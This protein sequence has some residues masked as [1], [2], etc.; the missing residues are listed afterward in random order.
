M[1]NNLDS[2][3]SVIVYLKFS[4][5][6]KYLEDFAKGNWYFNDAEFF[7]KL[8]ET[9]KIRGQGDRNELQYVISSGKL[10]AYDQRTMKEVFSSQF[11]KG[12]VSNKADANLPLLCLVGIETESLIKVGE[13]NDKNLYK[14]P[15]SDE[16]FELMREK[17]GKYCIIIQPIDLHKRLDE[18]K[19]THYLLFNKINYVKSYD[20]NKATSFF[21]SDFSRFFFK[22]EDLKYQREFRVC[23]FEKMPENHIFK[24]SPFLEENFKICDSN[25]LKRVLVTVLNE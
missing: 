6:K 2:K 7:R 13:E 9:T 10:V 3:T 15:F 17:F 4:N 20:K 8:E 5:N 1:K 21:R 12:I 11:N 14:L 25:I 24:V 18:L 16:E 19:K 22:D 23:I